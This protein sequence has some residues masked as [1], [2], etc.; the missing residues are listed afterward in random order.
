MGDRDFRHRETKKTK[1]TSRPVKVEALT[2][3]AEVEVV[4]KKRPRKDEEPSS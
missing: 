4:R 2:P 3:S 1:K